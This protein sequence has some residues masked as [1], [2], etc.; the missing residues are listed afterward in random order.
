MT[1]SDDATDSRGRALRTKVAALSKSR[2]N[3]C[4]LR[5]EFCSEDDGVEM[6]AVSH[7]I[8]A[9]VRRS[10]CSHRWAIFA[11]Q[12]QGALRGRARIEEGKVSWHPNQRFSPRLWA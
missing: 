10:R 9:S 11:A 6:S 8:R 5:R 3:N 12:S 1:L 2:R 4:A 7:L